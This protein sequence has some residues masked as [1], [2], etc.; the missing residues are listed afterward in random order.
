[1]YRRI[2]RIGALSVLACGLG[3]VGCEKAPPRAEAPPPR[4]GVRQAEAREMVDYDDFNGW[5]E[6]SATVEVRARVRGHIEEVHFTDGQLVEKDQLLFELDPRPFQAELNRAKEQLRIFQTQLVKAEKEEARVNEMFSNQVASDKEVEIATAARQSMEAEVDSSEQEI[7]RK[8]LDLEYSR[9][10]APIAGRIGRAML[11]AG[12]LVGAGGSDPVLTT[13]VSVDP[14]YIYFSVDER[15]LQRY[16]QHREGGRAASLEDQKIEISFGMDGDDGYPHKAIL[17]FADNRIDRTTGTA[18]VRARTSD[19]GERFTPG[20]RVRVRVPVSAPKRVVLVPDTAI[21]SD[22]DR[23]YLLVLDENNT[24]HRRDIRLGKLLDEG[25]R[26]VMPLSGETDAVAAGEW[27][28]A[29]GLQSA[30]LNYPVEP[31]RPTTQPAEMAA[32]PR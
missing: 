17:D 19:Q 8:E 12:N 29:Q 18:Q 4:V 2:V 25:L 13:I 23:K 24:V 6:S 20:S 30:R 32:A 5:L 15:S 26:V 10:T 22:Q 7:V 1:M 11:T 9:I 31:V 27:F 3:L 28:I 14:V 21:L 16:A